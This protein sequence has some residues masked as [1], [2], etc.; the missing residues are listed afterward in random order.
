[1]FDNQDQDLTPLAKLGEFKLIDHLTKDFEVQGENILKGIGDD[2]AVIAIGETEVQVVSTDLLIEGVHFDLAYYPLQHLGYKSVV[3]NLSDIYAM[4]AKPYG[5]TVS[6]ALSNR[7]TVEAMEAFY[8]GVRTACEKYGVDL[9]GGDTSSS[10]SGLMISITALGKGEKDKI[11]Y[12]D[13]A[14]INDLVCLT[15][16]IGAAYA[17]LQ[18]LN[19]EKAVFIKNPEMQ[20]ELD[21]HDYV[22]GRQLKPEAQK[23]I[24]EQLQEVELQPT[25][26]I[27]VSDGLASELF[28]LARNSKVGISVYADKVMLDPQTVSVAEDFD[29][30]PMTMAMNGGEDY[31]LLFTIS[32][33]DFQKVELLEDVKVIGHV[34]SEIEGVNLITQ[35][36]TYIPLQAQGWNHFSKEE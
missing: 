27:D 12:R 11:T 1:M 7:F 14:K 31:E 13:G 22:V 35:S 25:S 17:G 18:I 36:G 29:L 5:I 30:H 34:V 21:L 8:F 6:I 24:W 23:A 33:E 10:T 9:L 16:D 19:R 28:H 4:N 32:L 20:P 2:A 3:V 15:G 26:M